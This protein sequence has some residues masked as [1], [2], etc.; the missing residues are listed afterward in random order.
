[1]QSQA[2]S[3]EQKAAYLQ[4]LGALAADPDAALEHGLQACQFLDAGGTYELW[5]SASELDP[6]QFAPAVIE[7]VKE[8]FDEVLR[9]AVRHLCP[10]YEGRV[11]PKYRD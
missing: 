9:Q 8:Y 4:A 5:L 10:V 7:Q 2:P 1:M 6:S 3:E 11:F